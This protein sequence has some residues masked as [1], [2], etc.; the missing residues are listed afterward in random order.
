MVLNVYQL[1]RRNI[2][3]HLNLQV[4]KH[5]A[6]TMNPW[7]LHCVL[8]FEGEFNYIDKDS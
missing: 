2:P 7:M 4:V 6:V 1:T 5:L 8:V 3:E